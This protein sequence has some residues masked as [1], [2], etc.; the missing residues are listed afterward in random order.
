MHVIWCIILDSLFLPKFWCRLV[1]APGNGSSSHASRLDKGKAPMVEPEPIR[2]EDYG[3]EVPLSQAVSPT[4]RGIEI[5]IVGH[6]GG[7]Q[8][9]LA[10]SLKTDQGEDPLIDGREG[11]LV[12]L[13]RLQEL[14]GTLLNEKGIAV[15]QFYGG[16]AHD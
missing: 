5:V 16:M 12:E 15:G 2:G 10:A 14:T 1:M 7:D 6:Q 13:C 3:S 4:I 11:R 9:R 8:K